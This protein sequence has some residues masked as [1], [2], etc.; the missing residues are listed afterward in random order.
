MTDITPLNMSADFQQLSHVKSER[1]SRVFPS[2]PCRK[3]NLWYATLLH[4]DSELTTILPNILHWNEVRNKTWLL[5]RLAVWI[6][7][8]R[9][10]GVKFGLVFLLES[11]SA[12]P[13]LSYGLQQIVLSST[14]TR[15]L[16]ACCRGTPLSSSGPQGGDD[17]FLVFC[18]Q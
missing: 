3:R 9:S 14:F 2:F 11:R 18:F 12:E 8:R 16:K 17:V 4:V 1:M 6:P 10:F 15:L 13:H 5:S 7:F